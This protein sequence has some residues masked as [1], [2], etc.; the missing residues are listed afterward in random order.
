M[1]GIWRSDCAKGNTFRTAKGRGDD[2]LCRSAEA[3]I[4]REVGTA[5]RVPAAES[6]KQF[7]RK[8]RGPAFN[9]VPLAFAY[10]RKIHR[11]NAAFN[12]E[13]ML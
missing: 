13:W 10:L 8:C 2:R 6:E 1:R 3:V 9:V 12:E 5:D 7:A 11:R 4:R